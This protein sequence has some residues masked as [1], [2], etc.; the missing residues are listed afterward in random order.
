MYVCNYNSASSLPFSSLGISYA[1][2]LRPNKA[3]IAVHGC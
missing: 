2:L 3:E 1:M